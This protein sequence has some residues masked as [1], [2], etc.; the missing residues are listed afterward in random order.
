MSKISSDFFKSNREDFVRELKDNSI[1]CFFSSDKI[2]DGDDEDFVIDDKN[3]FY[4]TSVLQKDTKFVVTKSRRDDRLVVDYFLFVRKPNKVDKLWNGS[5]LDKE[6]ISFC[7]KLLKSQI[8]YEDEDM[9]FEDFFDKSCNFFDNIYF[10]ENKVKYTKSVFEY[11]LFIN[12]IKRK[13][14]NK[15][16]LN[17]KEI[18][19]NLREVKKKDE[20]EQIKNCIKVTKI[21]FDDVLKNIKSFNNEK[22]IEAVL[23]YNYTR[24]FAQNAFL[25]IVAS[26]RNSCVLH[27]KKNDMVLNKN[28]LVLIDTGARIN[29][30]RA[31]ISRTFPL[32]GRFSQR[33]RQIYDLVLDIQE[34]AISQIRVGVFFKDYETKVLSYVAEKLIENKIFSRRDFVEDSSIVRGYYPH[35]TSHFLGL[36]THDVGNFDGKFKENCVITVEPGIYLK[37]ENLG[38]RIEDNV[39]VTKKGAEVLSYEIPK[40]IEDI[41]NLINNN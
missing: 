8:I 32:S 35:L 22:D 21:A 26:S 37:D 13:F 6:R 12:K 23:I 29:N 28:S 4:L 25:P 36:D 31:D 3:L 41:E 11:D 20:I 33:E 5:L 16:F 17:S 34:F 10:Y 30:Y 7:S 18:L 19:T 40:S 1:A 9:S 2:I 24:N 14:S 27:Y 39:L 38:I 15:V